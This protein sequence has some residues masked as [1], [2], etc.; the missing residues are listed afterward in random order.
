MNI[1]RDSYLEQLINRKWNGMIKV[2]AGMRRSG[3][4]YLLF[5]LFVEHLQESGVD[6]EH[7][8]RIEL[9]RKENARYRSSDALY[10]L[11]KSKISGRGKYYVLID[12]I[13]G[14]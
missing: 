5:R 14:G 6:E 11:I 2:V 13:Q 10:D 7:I 9:D 12:E 3:K 1:A 4:S 8:V